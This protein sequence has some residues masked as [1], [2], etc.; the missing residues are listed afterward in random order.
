METRFGLDDEADEAGRYTMGEAAGPS[1]PSSDRF[2]RLPEPTPPSEMLEEQ[3][4][5]PPAPFDGD[6]NVAQD[7]ALRAGG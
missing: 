7:D 1:A 6:R 5:T 4:V 2:R 3:Q